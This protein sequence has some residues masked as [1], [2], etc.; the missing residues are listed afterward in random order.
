MLMMCGKGIEWILYRVR[1]GDGLMS[2]NLIL[3]VSELGR[4]GS[5]FYM[6]WNWGS[7][8]E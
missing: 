3:I 4:N 5:G 6:V 7:S 1:N 8:K 2:T